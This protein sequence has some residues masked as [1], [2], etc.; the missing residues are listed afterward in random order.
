MPGLSEVMVFQYMVKVQLIL[1][2]R[3]SHTCGGDINI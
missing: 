1:F 3:E 2:S